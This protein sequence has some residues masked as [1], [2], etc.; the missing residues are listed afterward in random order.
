MPEPLTNPNAMLTP[1][2]LGPWVV[3]AVVLVAGVVLF[4]A[5]A[6]RVPCLLQALADR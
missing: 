3:F 2:R 1:R 5:F 6:D 4:F